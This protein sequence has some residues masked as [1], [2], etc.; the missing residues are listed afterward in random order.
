MRRRLEAGGAGGAR[1]AAV[2]AL[3]RPLVQQPGRLRGGTHACMWQVRYT[4][5][6]GGEG[7]HHAAVCTCRQQ[8][9]QPEPAHAGGSS[10]PHAAAAAHSLTWVGPAS[11]RALSMYSRPASS[12]CRAAASSDAGGRR[13][14]QAGHN[15]SA[16]TDC[17]ERALPMGIA[18]AACSPGARNLA[19]PHQGC[20]CSTS[21]GRGRG[22]PGGRQL[23]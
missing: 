21:A 1:G 8:H 7:L 19:L 3:G 13:Q 16:T 9:C 10:E 23:G 5:Q 15:R 14:S 6:G 17:C 2:G 11:I 20:G 22:L 18:H 4:P 12:R